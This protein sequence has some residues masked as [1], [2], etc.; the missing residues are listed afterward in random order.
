MVLL[1]VLCLILPASADLVPGHADTGFFPG[2]GADNEVLTV[3]V[4]ADGRILLGGNFTT[5][6]T[7]AHNRIV[8]L[9]ADGTLDTS[10]DPGNGADAR[11]R[12]IAVQNDGR[13]LIGGSF[14]SVGGTPLNRIARLNA[15]GSV[16]PSFDS[17]SGLDNAIRSIAV[18][19]DG[20]AVIGGD[21]TTVDGVTRNGLAR[22]NSDGSL[23]TTFDPGDG[24]SS[25]VYDVEVDANGKTL[26]VGNFTFFDGILRRRIA[27][28]NADGSLDTSFDPGAGANSW[29]NALALQN[30]GKILIGGNF[31]TVDGTTR[32]RIAR[33]NSDGSLD[34]SFDPG[35]GANAVINAISVQDDGMVVV[36][37]AFS[38]MDGVSRGHIARLDASG[39]LDTGYKVG[40]GFDSNVW[41]L[42]LQVD[43]KVLAGGQFTDFNGTGRIRIARL[44]IDGTLDVGLDTGT[45]ANLAVSAVVRQPDGK[46]LIGGYF[47]SVDGTT[48]NRVARLNANGSLD[49]DFDPGTGANSA[50]RAMAL[51]GDGKVLI[52]GQFTDYDGTTR[53]RVARLNSGGSLDTGFGPSTGADKTVYAVAPQGSGKVLIGGEFSQVNGVTRKGI[54]RLNT[55]GSLDTGFDPGSGVN[56]NAYVYALAVQPDDKVLVGGNFTTIDSVA[57]TRIARLNADGSLDTTF[58]P[59]TGPNLP[60]R[61][62]ALQPDGKV[63][64]G[65][66]F[67]S[68]SGQSRNR[69]ARLNDDGTL[70]TSFDPGT[71]A[72]SWV[73]AVA[74]QS[75]GKVLIGGD[76]T[77]VDGTDCNRIARL[78]ADGSVDTTFVTSSGAD[79]YVYD[80]TIQPDGMVLI[81]GNFNRKVARLNGATPPTFTS[82]PAPA[83]GKV[84]LDYSHSFAAKGYPWTPRFHLTTGSLPPGLTLDAT[85][86]LFSGKPSAAGVYSVTVSA[87]NYVAPCAADEVNLNIAKGD[88]TTTIA[89]HTPDPSAAGQVVTVE[90]SVNSG[91]GTPTGDVTV[92]D[93]TTSCTGSVADGAC[94]LTFATAGT[95]TLTAA[96]AGDAN[97]NASVS[98]AVAHTVQPRSSYTVYLPG[99][100]RSQP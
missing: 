86:G 3:A 76:F 20:K 21:F 78:N 58:D 44:N 57:R 36:G 56:V 77:T 18:Q 27:R 92:G 87:C 59:G 75:D 100:L 49:S 74:V 97:M 82:A 94:A 65:G 72:N 52:A 47:T 13:I 85:T 96:Y 31:S 48:R 68:V 46:V 67:T 73:D 4:Q 23:D 53:G 62:V 83:S 95:K 99:V 45:G 81:G 55:N 30:D 51:Q 66:S 25:G 50:I 26:I 24:P 64:I 22:L 14:T 93:G 70:D 60:V 84:G 1:L 38:T 11:V 19:A 37:G 34:T 40:S 10:F 91:A 79:D 33:L 12:A 42:V 69:I 2:V 63:I 32:T 8:R 16:D 88:T 5:F 71:G 89:A 28:L 80:I 35:T 9:N 90:Y 17:G 98:P 61:D 6:N 54:A 7:V 41:D 43:G 29:I 39:A 15:D